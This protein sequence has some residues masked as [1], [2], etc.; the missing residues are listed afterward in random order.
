MKAGQDVLGVSKMLT[1]IISG[2]IGGI[3]ALTVLFFNQNLYWLM[4]L[5]IGVISVLAISEIFNVLGISKNFLIVIPTIIFT[6]ILPLFGFNIYWEAV[7]YLYTLITFSSMVW[8]KQVKLKEICVVYS[9]AILI[10]F[11]LFKIVDLRNYGGN[12]GSFYVFLAL[13]ISWMTDTGAYFFGKMFG[14]SKLCPEISP[15]KTKEGFIGGIVFCLLCVT[16]IAFMFN[17]FIFPQKKHINY[18]VII[19]MSLFGSLISSLGDLCFSAFK[20]K[21]GVKDFGNIMPGHG[22]VLDRF[23]SVIFVVPYVYLFLKFI[24][25]MY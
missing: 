3:F 5:V 8:Y 13:A 1:R 24:P 2:V 20:R 7:F 10:S 22:G 15:K 23:D 11:S 18:A 12:Y 25:V 19:T 16:L 9:M 17:N 21:C 6:P 14:K 4:N